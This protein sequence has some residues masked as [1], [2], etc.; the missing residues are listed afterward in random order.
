MSRSRPVARAAAVAG[1]SVTLLVAPAPTAS[2][3]AAPET[4]RATA[5]PAC[6]PAVASVGDSDGDGL[7]DT[8]DGC[9]TVASSNP[10][11]CPSASRRA[12]LR[13]VKA[14]R[15][16]EARI[17]SPVTAC[18]ARARIVLWRVR[19]D[20]DVKQVAAS[21]TYSGKR[22]FSVPRGAAY[23]VTVSASYSTGVAECDQAT[24]R[25]VQV[26]R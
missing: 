22:R 12:R 7:P 5:G 25:T 3:Y 18:A 26:P 9:P 4:C 10:T 8:G 24:S 6:T 21:A 15:R 1:L 17:S 20:R 11:G 13:W 19:P 16:L 2:A 23:Y 14:D